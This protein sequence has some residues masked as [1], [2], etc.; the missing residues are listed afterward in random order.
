MWCQQSGGYLTTV[1]CT[2]A[3]F[4]AQLKKMYELWLPHH[5]IKV[6]CEHQRQLTYATFGPDEACVMT[7]FS[8][9]Y[10]HKAFAS[11]CCEQPH[12]SNMDVSVVSYAEMEGGSRIIGGRG[13]YF[14]PLM[15]HSL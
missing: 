5:W 10:D 15:R 6:W 11:K 7:D 8:A 3:Q 12:H 9:V 4:M 1:E 13:G 2:R 14:P